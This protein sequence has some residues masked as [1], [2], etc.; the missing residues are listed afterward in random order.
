[1]HK[2]TSKRLRGTAA[3]VAAAT[4]MLTGC[5]G[6]GGGDGEDNTL[7]IAYG[8]DYVFLSPELGEEWWNTV[9]E[10][11]KAENPGAEVEFVPI[12][13]GFNDIVTKLSL[14]YRDPSTA[15]DVAQLPTDQLSLW[16]SSGY[17]AELDDYVQDAD[18]WARFPDSVKAETSLDGHVYS[19]SHGENTN[20]LYYNIPMFTQAGI[21]VPWQPETWDDVLG[22]AEKIRDLE[23][24]A[25]PL[26]LIGGNGG[27]TSALQFSGGN[28]LVGASTESIFDD[29]SGKW[30]VDSPGLREALQFYVDTAANG[31]QAPASE[32]LNPN[33]V[34]NSFQLLADQK[35]A[36]AVG[37]NFYGPLW[38]E[39]VCAPCFPEAAETYGV[40]HIPTAEGGGVASVLGGWSLA[41]GASSSN[42]D[43]AWKFIEAAQTK[44]N[45]I[46]AANGAGWVSPD[47]DTWEDPAFVDFAPAYQT[48]FAEILPEAES[49]PNDPN[50]SIWAT[51]FGM[52]TAEI[53]QKPDTT[54]DQAIKILSDYVSGQLGED[55]VVTL[56]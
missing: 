49:F 25:W 35:A 3:A 37:G 36:I 17:L 6:G 45:L 50:F 27:G 21:E 24:G 31:L 14:L 56:S 48:F 32:L 33:A 11:F 26:W 55:A 1:M 7:T 5:A 34:V 23:N 54:V 20:A 28:L 15:P 39:G 22:A 12:P 47:S 8:S 30:V 51:G 41:V 46:N 43:L 40:A 29:D 19:V 10:E 44:E 38:S 53:I 52:A 42:P 18:W 4:L 13:G 16:A 2:R 9:A